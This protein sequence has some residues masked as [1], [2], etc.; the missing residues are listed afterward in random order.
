MPSWDIHEKYARLMD[1]PVE[2]AREINRFIDDPRWHDFFDV[3]LERTEIPS[4]RVIGGRIIIYHFR[5]SIF[6]TPAWES[7]RKAIERYG[8]NGWRAFFL[9][10]WLDLIERNMRSDKGFAFIGLEA[11]DYY[12]EYIDE[13]GN[14]LEERID[15]VLNDIRN[16]ITKKKRKRSNYY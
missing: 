8:D 11:T 1:I 6:Y 7:F 2:V 3:A 9:H 4:L 16:Y 13:V 14:F 10:I 15:E 12:K 5:G